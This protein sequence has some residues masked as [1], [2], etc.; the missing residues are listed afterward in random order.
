LRRI[1]NQLVYSGHAGQALKLIEQA[2]PE[3]G[4]GREFL[5]EYIQELNLSPIF[6]SLIELNAR[7]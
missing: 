5:R 3:P 1:A 7:L 4:L 6:A 2:R